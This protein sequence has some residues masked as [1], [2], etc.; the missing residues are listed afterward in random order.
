MNALHLPGVTVVTATRG[1]P[2][3]LRAAVS[4]IL[5]QDYPGE[6]ELIVVFDQTEIDSLDDVVVPEGRLLGTMSNTR[7]PGLAG[8]RNTGILGAHHELIAF[9]D[10]D[11]E[12]MPSKLSKQV[13]A[14]NNEPEA[15]LV[16]SGIRIQTTGSAY[17]RLPPRRAAFSDFLA[18]RITEIHPSTFLIRRADLLGELGL[19]DEQLPN[20]YGEDYDLLLRASRLGH[21]LSVLEPLTLVHWDRSSFFTAKWRGVADGLTYILGKFPEFESNPRGSARMEG[22]IAFAQAAMGDRAS[23][24]RWARHALAHNPLQM[25]AWAALIVSV[26]L[27]PPATLVR[28]VNLRGRGL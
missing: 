5:G 24:R 27:L 16:A 22:Q 26:R 28:L 7:T 9:C 1:R 12:W 21:V 19:I 14:W 11:D 6:I 18:S 13:D 10:D 17:D 8:G 15:T 2:K 20:S 23:A 25:R 3:M 4:A